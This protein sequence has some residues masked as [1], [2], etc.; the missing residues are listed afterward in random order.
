MMLHYELTANVLQKILRRIVEK[1]K[2]DIA[3]TNGDYIANYEV[4]LTLFTIVQQSSYFVFSE[5]DL[6]RVFH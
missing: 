1:M 5:L 6:V 4:A 2:K 3:L